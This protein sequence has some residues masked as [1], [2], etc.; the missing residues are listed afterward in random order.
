MDILVGNTGFVGHNLSKQHRFTYT[1]NSQNIMDAYGISPDLCVYSGIRAEKFRADH[2]PDEDLAHVQNA[3]ENIRKINP[4]HLVLISTVDVIPEMQI[5]DVYEDTLYN[6]ANLTPY[7]EHR[8]LLENEV[9][10]LY[11]NTLIIRLPALFGQGLKKNF[12]FDLISYVPAMLKKSKYNELLEKQERLGYFYAED[13]NGFFRLSSGILPEEQANLKEMFEKLGF[14]ALNFTDSRSTF[15]FYN[16][17]YLWYHIEVLLENHIKLAHMATEVVSAS[18][19]Y[20]TIYGSDFENEIQAVPFD[21]RFFK[22][23][24]GKLLGSS[25]DYI[26]DKEKV[27]EEIDN[28]VKNQIIE[29][30]L[31]K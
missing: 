30:K 18:E 29:R 14:S 31:A 10:K 5:Q 7:G 16:L 3:L 17:N 25:D 12:I 20:K 9:R 8:I 23:R 2:F 22:T 21:Y 28:F 1:F 13:A 24:Y 15:S 4:R 6:T 26:F 11:P 27:T 19:I